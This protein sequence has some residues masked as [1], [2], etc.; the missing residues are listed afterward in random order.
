MG[1]SVSFFSFLRHKKIVT[2]GSKLMKNHNKT[3][4]SNKGY[5]RFFSFLRQKRKKN[6][7]SKQNLK[8]K[9]NNLKQ[10]KRK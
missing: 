1:I 10:C 2:V 6:S 3:K 8:C 7:N 9:Y 4:V 5:M